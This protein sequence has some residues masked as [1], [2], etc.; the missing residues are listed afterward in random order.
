MK[1]VNIMQLQGMTKMVG[2]ESQISGDSDSQ[3]DDL[4]V[5]SLK[6]TNSD[7][8]DCMWSSDS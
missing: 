2:I 1:C 5:T 7:V 6:C 4:R 8:K 3:K